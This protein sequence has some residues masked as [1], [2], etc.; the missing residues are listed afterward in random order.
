MNR[1]P[2]STI[3][4]HNL[5][6]SYL[7]AG[8]YADSLDLL[9][10]N[11][12][13]S[14]VASDFGW[15]LAARAAIGMQN[16]DDAALYVAKIAEANLQLEISALLYFLRGQESEFE[17]TMTKILEATANDIRYAESAAAVYTHIG[18]VETA[19][20]WLEQLDTGRF[21]FIQADIRWSSLNGNSRW[22]ELLKR[23]GVSQETL[24]SIEFEVMLPE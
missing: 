17:A 2:L 6:D 11:F 7:R 3:A 9:E 22:E 16:A 4:V 8:R 1:D 23:A 18:N 5:A 24:D 14:E 15:F 20:A 12:D 19:L 21:A 13:V 10:K